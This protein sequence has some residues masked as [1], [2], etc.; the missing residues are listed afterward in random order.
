MKGKWMFEGNDVVFPYITFKH[1]K[2]EKEHVRNMIE[3]WN[4]HERNVGI[5]M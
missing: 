4:K 1:I 2:L 3:T 5:N